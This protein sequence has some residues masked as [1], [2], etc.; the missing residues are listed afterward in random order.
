MI[1]EHVME[2]TKLQPQ[3]LPIILFFDKSKKHVSAKVLAI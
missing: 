3:T 1:I 2:A